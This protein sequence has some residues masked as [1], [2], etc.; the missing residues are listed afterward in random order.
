MPT[1]KPKGKELS[2]NQQK[3]NRKISSF[4]ILVEHAIGGIKKCRIVKE[5]FRCR[6]FGFD[7][8]VMLIACALHNF[9]MSLN[10]C[11]IKLYSI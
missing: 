2:E 11:D 8:V 1:K 7:D 3:E 6:K 9:R 10:M 5:R 4:R